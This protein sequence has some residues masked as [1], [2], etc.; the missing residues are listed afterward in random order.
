MDVGFR[1][2]MDGALFYSLSHRL[3]EEP[4]IQEYPEPLYLLPTAPRNKVPPYFGKLE[5]FLSCTPSR[6]VENP[7][8]RTSQ[9]ERYLLN[10][11]D[12]IALETMRYDV[13][14]YNA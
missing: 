10:G 9:R 7:R 5:V 2:S 12:G 6:V 1:E 13:T 3:G 8:V 14:A 4:A 11:K